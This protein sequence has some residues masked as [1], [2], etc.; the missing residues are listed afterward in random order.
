MKN[1]GAKILIAILLILSFWVG[2]CFSE[3][4]DVNDIPRP[5]HNNPTFKERVEDRKE[6]VKEQIKERGVNDPNV[7][8]AMQ[9]VPRH[10]FVGKNYRYRA[11]Y[12]S[13]LP[14]GYGQTISQPYIVAY[15]TEKLELEKDDKVLEIGTG[16]GYQAAVCAEI[17]KE[18]YTIEIIEE[19]ANSAERRL[20]K[21]GY[22]NVFTKAG[23]GYYGWPEEEPFDNIIVTSAAAFVP[24]PLMKQLK[25]NG[26]M[27]IPVGSPYG[28]QRLVLVEKDKDKVKT[29]TLMP[30]RFVP[31]TGRVQEGK[32]K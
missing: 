21:L 10:A 18:V 20:K 5:D 6:M 30:V 26:K 3:S 29:R 31:M 16:S 1:S 17:C 11:Y 14:I 24:P 22:N 8:K 2:Q 13:P 9:T 32:K 7:L 15:M 4:E 27:V 12:D 23:D 19:L 25:E 28:N